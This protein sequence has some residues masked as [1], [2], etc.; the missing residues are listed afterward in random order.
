MKNFVT[1]KMMKTFDELADIYNRLL[2]AARRKL[3]DVT[4]Y[5]FEKIEILMC[6]IPEDEI[7]SHHIIH[8]IMNNEVVDQPEFISILFR[9]KLENGVAVGWEKYSTL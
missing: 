5:P 4:Q 6:T 9:K 2:I 8:K 7:N 1:L 3:P